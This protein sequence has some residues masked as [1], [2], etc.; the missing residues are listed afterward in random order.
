MPSFASFKTTNSSYWRYVNGV[1][2]W[3]LAWSGNMW[4]TLMDAIAAA[5]ATFVPYSP[6]GITVPITP[7]A[8]PFTYTAG[9]APENIYISATTGAVSSVTRHGQPIA[10]GL[11]LHVLLPPGGQLTVT[12]TGAAPFMVKDY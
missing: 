2:A 12:Y 9:S 10:Y 1:P 11:P 4:D 8:S 6:A 7:G 5:V 3:Y